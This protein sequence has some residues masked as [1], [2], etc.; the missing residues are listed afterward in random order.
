MVVIMQMLS[1][2]PVPCGMLRAVLVSG[3]AISILSACATN[4]VSPSAPVASLSDTPAAPAAPSAAPSLFNVLRDALGN[5]DEQKLPD[6]SKYSGGVVGGKKSGVGIYTWPDGARYEGDWVNDRRNGQG[7]WTSANGDRYEGNWVNDQRTGQGVY[8]FMDGR[9]YEG[10]WLNDQKTGQGIY[11]L[12]D[13][14]RYEGEFLQDNPTG[15]GISTDA[16]GVSYRQLRYGAFKEGEP[17]L[18]SIAFGPGVA[19]FATACNGVPEGWSMIEGRCGQNGPEGDVRLVQNDG[20]SDFRGAFKAGK[21]EGEMTQSFLRK[22]SAGS[23]SSAMLKGTASGPSAFTRAELSRVELIDNKPVWV[24]HFRGS[25]QGPEAKGKGRCL[26]RGAWEECELKDGQRVDRIYTARV[27]AERKKQAQAERARQLQAEKAERLRKAE[28]AKL[29]KARLAQAAKDA[30]LRK[31]E[32][33][34]LEKARLAQAAADAKR[35]KARRVAE[36]A[37]AATAAQAQASAAAAAEANP[38]PY[39]S[40]SAPAA[41]SA[42]AADD[43]ARAFAGNMANRLI[44]ESATGNDGQK[45]FANAFGAWVAQQNAPPQAQASAAGAADQNMVAACNQLAQMLRQTANLI[46]QGALNT[47]ERAIY[48]LK[49]G[50]YER[51]CGPITGSITGASG[52]ARP[53]GPARAPIAEAPAAPTNQGY[54]EAPVITDPYFRNRGATP[55]VAPRPIVPSERCLATGSEACTIGK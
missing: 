17:P 6:G 8:K 19:K 33:A 2:L 15:S 9:R 22:D 28:E 25:L 31:I 14:R 23:M 41:A 4:Q 11:T 18:I 7:V 35:E 12:V 10:A 3:L 46:K 16:K 37:R 30:K 40:P 54:Y 48:N 51:D 5:R 47:P 38:S 55:K 34:K 29:E 21:P 45:L 36:R 39:P 24:G 32:E 27:E 49:L 44:A 50:G 1:M 43:F 53:N 26:Y 13:G 52:G 42:G 20:M